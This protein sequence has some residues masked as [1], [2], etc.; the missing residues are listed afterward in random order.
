MTTFEP[1]ESSSETETEMV[2]LYRTLK[3]NIRLLN[4]RCRA[5]WILLAINE[6]KAYFSRVKT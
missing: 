1:V 2:F 4:D 6:D 5:G 3:P